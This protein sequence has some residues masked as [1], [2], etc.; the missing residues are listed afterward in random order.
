MDTT[1]VSRAARRAD[2][3]ER[4]VMGLLVSTAETVGIAAGVAVGVSLLTL[5]IVLLVLRRRR[6]PPEARVYGILRELDLRMA[7]LGADL[8]LELERTRDESRRARNHESRVGVV[9]VDGVHSTVHRP[10]ALLDEELARL[11]AAVKASQQG[12]S[13]HGGMTSERKLRERREN[14]QSG[15]MAGVARGQDE[16]GLRQ[17]E[18]PGDRLERRVGKT[19]GVEHNRERV[20]GET[21]A[22]EHIKG[23]KPPAHRP[24][25][26]Q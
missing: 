7:Q 9:F 19:R 5:G 13:P 14:P 22:G 2:R 16:D 3:R 17:V 8:S 18:F 26:V 12:G 6:V 25:S 23:D 15:A 4:G 1:T 11:R 21:L 10:H 24:L 20:A